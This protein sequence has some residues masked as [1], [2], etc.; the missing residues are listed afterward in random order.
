MYILGTNAASILNKTESFYRNINVFKPAAFFLQETKTRFKNKLKHPDYSFFEYIRTNGGGGGLITAVHNSLH[1]VSVGNEDETEVLVVEAK[2]DDSKI[3]LINGYGPQETDEEESKAFMNRIDLEVK[4]AKL[5]GAFVC[6]EMDANSKLGPDIVSGDPNDQSRNG[7]LLMNVVEENNL[8]VVNASDICEGVITRQR[9]TIDRS[10]KST[11]DFFIVCQ[12]FFKHIKRLKVDEEKKYSLCSY[13]KKKGD[14]HIK[15]SDHNLLY[16][17]VEKKW[18]TVIGNKREEIFNFNDDDGLKKFIADTSTNEALKNCFDDDQE[19][20]EISSARWIKNIN[21]SI[22]K[23]FRKIRIGKKKVNSKLEGLFQKKE[24]IMESLSKLENNDDVRGYEKAH[25]DLNDVEAEIA[26]IC[27]ETN[28]KIVEDYLG[29]WNDGI[30]GFSQ[31]KTWKLK[32]RLAPK[33]T[34][35]PPAAKKDKFGNLVTDKDGLETLY[36]DTYKDRLK[37]NKIKDGLEELESLKMY[38][39]KLRLKYSSQ[40]IFMNCINMGERI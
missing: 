9:D 14:I 30:E 17:E 31:P 7:K 34:F 40:V 26:N 39:F 36:I 5:A 16:I 29:T 4:R 8:V 22:K 27:S 37:P 12:N 28:K 38:L 3:R 19:D 23:C 10:E 15:N 1:P 2:V 6:I 11:I 18:T 35:E 21:S 25:N 32:K 13:S 24:F 20:I 33:N